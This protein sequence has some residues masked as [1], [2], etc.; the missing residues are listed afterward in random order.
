MR[1]SGWAG[2]AVLALGAGLS[3]A[4]LSGAGGAA[5]GEADRVLAT[6]NGTAITLGHVAVLRDSLPAQYQAIPDPVLFEAILDQLIQQTVL[7]QAA[8]EL[9]PRDRIGLENIERDFV[10]RIAITGIGAAAITEAALA[11]AYRARYETAAPQTEWN[12][13]HILVATE[14]EAARL[15]AEIEAGA[16]FAELA[17]AHSIDRG[18]AGAGGALGWFGPGMMV[19]Q[20]E[21]AVTALEPGQ[22]GG[23]VQTQFGWHIVTVIDRRIAAVPSLDAV[24]DD[25]AAEIGRAA[26]DARIAE[27]LAAATIE[28]HDDG[29]DPA[30]MRDQ[31]LFD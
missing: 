22:I 6:V 10:A 17:R 20:F 18:S 5:A 1:L 27:L 25:L 28:R 4:G 13:A 31:T 3:G 7:A 19:P 14:E 9:G 16:D 8:G 21:A 24:R 15:R 12:A 23:P 11:E 30:L 2:A 26:V 29:V